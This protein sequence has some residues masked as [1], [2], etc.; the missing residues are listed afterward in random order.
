[1]SGA[2]GSKDSQVHFA[3]GLG[4]KIYV[5]VTPSPTW[6]WADVAGKSVQLALECQAVLTAS[7]GTATA[8]HGARLAVAA[9]DLAERVKTVESAQDLYDVI[10]SYQ[11]FKAEKDAFDRVAKNDN[12]LAEAAAAAT[13]LAKDAQELVRSRIEPFKAQL[14]EI[15]PTTW[16]LVNQVDF[17]HVWDATNPSYWGAMAGCDTVQLTVFDESFDKVT[18]FSTGADDSWIATEAA[19]VRARYGSLWQQDVN[20]G[21][22]DWNDASGQFNL[23]VIYEHAD[24][25]G[26]HQSFEAG[27]YSMLESIGDN[28]LSSLRVPPGWTVRLHKYDNCEGS[29]VVFTGDTSYVGDKYN[30]WA[31]SITVTGPELTGAAIY[32]DADFQGREQILAPGRYDLQQ[33]SLG[34]DRLS[35]I[36]LPS[37]WSIT[38][39]RD[40]GFSGPS[41]T[42]NRDTNY[43]GDLYDNWTSSVVVR[44]TTVGGITLYKDSDYRGARQVLAA[45]SYDLDEIA[46]GG[47]SVSS[48]RIPPG[49]R[50]VLY[51]HK[52]FQ[53]RSKELTRDTSFV[54]DSFNDLTSSLRVYHDD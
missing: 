11:A 38:L 53:G 36:R 6:A 14:Q 25:Q 23:P 20:A 9:N 32:Q 27:R 52:G 43:V 51:E 16:R 50:V 19:I 28:K 54:D 2:W 44:A 8:V 37:G 10:K 13:K 34:N 47:D 48:I 18:T 49:W 12:L 41:M 21:W 35:S 39:Y 30:D 45:G 46:L 1:M 40:A 24:F 3:N 5:L 17:T 26:W 22:I 15:K 7:A 33:L 29:S 4:R 42:F 31:S